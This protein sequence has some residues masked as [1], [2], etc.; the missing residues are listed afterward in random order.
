[1]RDK[2]ET[3]EAAAR[4]V[5]DGAEVVMQGRMVWSPM[6]I[7]REVVRQGTQDLR[8]IGI[9]GSSINVDFLVGANRAASVDTCSCGMAPFARTG[10]NFARHVTEGRLKPMDNT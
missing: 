1:M 7:L 8:L 6:A 5:T 2:L 4:H 3:L 9:T 10:P